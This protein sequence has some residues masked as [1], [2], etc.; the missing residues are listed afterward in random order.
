MLKLATLDHGQMA[1][2]LAVPHL[3]ETEIIWTKF[4]YVKQSIMA[5]QHPE[6]RISTSTMEQTVKQTEH[7][8]TGL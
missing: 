5:S 8:W 4:R 6:T 1:V 2:R 7:L 3:T